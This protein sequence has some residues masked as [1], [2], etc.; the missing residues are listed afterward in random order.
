MTIAAH[1][2]TR[3][4]IQAIFTRRFVSERVAQLLY[5]KCVETVNEFL[6]ENDQHAW[7]P[8]KYAQLIGAINA[9]FDS[10]DLKLVTAPDEITGRRMLCLVNLK[11][12]DLVQLATEYNPAEIAF[13]KAL[14]EEIATAPSECFSISS[15]LALK[16]LAK[17]KVGTG[18]TKMTHAHGEVLLDSFVAN[19]W[20]SKSASGRYTL[21]AR[22]R[23]ELAEYL[24]KNF[25]ELEGKEHICSVCD[26]LVLSGVRCP[27]PQCG[28]RVH[29]CCIEQ[30]RKRIR[31]CPSCGFDWSNVT[32]R[33]IGEEVLRQ[34]GD[35]DDGA[36]AGRRRVRKS[37]NNLGSEEEEEDE[38]DDRAR[39]AARKKGKKRVEQDEE[40]EEEVAT[41]MQ[42]DQ[43]GPDEQ[44]RRSGGRRR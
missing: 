36:G 8:E 2:S 39:P 11:G 1:D 23:F 42:V 22:A 41:Q 30:S 27:Q 43:D 5:R 28:F 7:V 16:Q 44:P 14:L 33:V 19:G 6:P 3:L 25:E 20:L 40:D 15:M 32:M 12:D 37:Q 18:K 9:R 24:S 17:A 29:R 34:G 26:H 21:G 4:F 35:A 31:L 13:F 38:E 10:L